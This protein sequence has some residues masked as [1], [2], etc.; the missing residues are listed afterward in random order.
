M[1]SRQFQKCAGIAGGSFG[2][3]RR[4]RGNSAVLPVGARITRRGTECARRAAR[5]MGGVLSRVAQA[6]MGR[7]VLF[8]GLQGRG[9]AEPR[10]V[11][12]PR[13]RARGDASG[14]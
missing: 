5:L 11:A 9:P 4:L 14:S 12:V 7:A 10:S 8:A 2:G 13:L 1:R 6:H 3:V